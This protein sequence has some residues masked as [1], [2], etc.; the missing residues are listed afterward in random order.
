MFDINVQYDA[1]ALIKKINEADD[2]IG[3]FVETEKSMHA[4]IH[5]A[6]CVAAAIYHNAPRVGKSGRRSA[7]TLTE[8]ANM[9]TGRRWKGAGDVKLPSLQK[10]EQ[11][12]RF[13]LAG[14]I[15][16]HDGVILTGKNGNVVNLITHND[17]K[18]TLG[19]VNAAKEA[20]M[21][22]PEIEYAINQGHDA[23]SAYDSL[24]RT[25]RQAQKAKA[26]ATPTPEPAPAP[27]PAPAKVTTDADL[28]ASVLSIL[29]GW[30]NDGTATIDMVFDKVAEIAAMA[31]P[32]TV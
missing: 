25:V 10:P 24:V 9:L 22:N 28:V 11:V 18:G 2:L 5:E 15:H 21:S 4:A 3:K 7:G 14:L 26:E 20:G 16:A 6:A 13:A 29:N 31:I 27:A 8:V 17:I 19:W 32:A 30:H 23:Q 1:T 12:T